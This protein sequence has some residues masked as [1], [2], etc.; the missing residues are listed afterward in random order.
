MSGRRPLLTIVGATATGK[1]ALAVE[2]AEPFGGEVVSVDAYA[3]YRGLDIGTA[4]P[5]PGER[6]RV[7]HHLI[8]V[9]EPDEPMT[10][11]RYLDAAHLALEDIWRRGRLPVLAGGTGQYFWAIIE[12]WQVP[13]VE[14]DLAL[15]AEL[16]QLAESDGAI[17]VHQRLAAIDPVAAGRLDAL[18]TRRVIRALEV[19]SRTGL[20]LSA[21]QRRSPIDADVFILGLR[22]PR[23]EHFARLDARVDAMFAAGF[24]DEV[25]R[26]REAGFG[27]ASPVRSG[28][29]YKEISAYLDGEYGIAEAVQRTKYANHRLARRQAAWF[30]DADPRIHWLNMADAKQQAHDMVA[31]WLAARQEMAC[32]EA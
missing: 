27:D 6:A 5:S 18:N 26:L 21:C 17:A 8:D 10:L 20:P 15:R 24:V 23:D 4:K 25:K 14:P 16:E 11:A 32:P 31:S 13:R 28:V 9:A 12:G 29:G 30:K 22:A 1:S 3:V 19:V 7:P 2:L